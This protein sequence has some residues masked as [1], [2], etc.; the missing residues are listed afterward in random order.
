MRCRELRGLLE[1]DQRVFLV[2]HWDADGVASAALFKR[3]LGGRVVGHAVPTIGLYS[4]DAVPQPP[5]GV[6]AVLVLDYGVS[7]SEYEKLAERLEVQLYALDHHRVQPPRRGL[8]GYCN[9]VAFGE[10]G[11][12]SYPGASI[13]AYEV[14]GAP[15]A[16]GD[17]LLAALGGVGDLAPYVDSGRGHPGLDRLRKL[18]RGAQASLPALRSLAEAIDSC[19]RL[20]DT[21]C[22]ARAVERAAENP[23]ALTRDPELASALKRARSLVEEALASL[24]PLRAAGALKAYRLVMDAY[25]T[26]AVGRRLAAQNP[27]AVVVLVHFIPRQGRAVIYIR[28]VSRSLVQLAERLRGKGVKAAGKESVVVVDVAASSKEAEA[29]AEEILKEV[30]VWL[31]A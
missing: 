7:G 16:P 13:L 8:A 22:L 2:H 31:S 19:Y 30:E 26:S 12:N 1:G 23:H 14:L 28:S 25:V 10:A 21:R 18:L 6:D 11:E 17:M 5:P 4:A 29:L 27:D 3:H 20:L 24:E 15:E 9:P